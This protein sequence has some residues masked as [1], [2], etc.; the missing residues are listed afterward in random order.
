MFRKS[1]T[2]FMAYVP[3]WM[4]WDGSQQRATELK[5]RGKEM[6]HR[7]QFSQLN[8]CPFFHFTEPFQILSPDPSLLI[9]CLFHHTLL[10]YC[11]C[12]YTYKLHDKLDFIFNYNISEIEIP[13]TFPLLWSILQNQFSHHNEAK[14]LF[15]IYLYYYKQ[16]ETLLNFH[17]CRFKSMQNRE[18]NQSIFFINPLANFSYSFLI[19]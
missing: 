13:R 3:Y 5:L 14:D 16:A 18:L 19:I 6:I 4:I 1:G 11:K 8:L 2:I 7:Q 15:C 9:L 17:Y 12:L 10:D